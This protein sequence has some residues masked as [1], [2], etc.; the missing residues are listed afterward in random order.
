[1]DNFVRKNNTINFTSYPQK[2][3]ISH[4]TISYLLFDYLASIGT[5]TVFLVPGGGNMFLVDAAGR[6]P[7]IKCICTHNEQAAVIAAESYSRI[8]KEVGVALVTTGPGATNS[9]TG[10]AGAWLDSVPILIISGQVKRADINNENL[11]RQ[12]GPQEIDIVSM[13]KGI[14]KYSKTILDPNIFLNELQKAV[15]ISK[16]G[17]PGPCLIDIPLDIQSSELEIPNEYNESNYKEIPTQKFR[18]DNKL[19]KMMYELKKSKKPLLLM[20]MGVKCSDSVKLAKKLIEITNIP[21]AFTWPVSDILPYNHDL[22]VG[23]P[24]VVAKRNA[25]IT[26][27]NSDFL[28]SIGARLDRIV[29]AF[30]PENFA[31]NAKLFCVD[32]DRAELQKHPKR[33]RTI[34]SDAGFFIENLLEKINKVKYVNTNLRWNKKCLDLK[35][36]YGKNIFSKKTKFSVYQVVENLSKIIPKHSIIITGS[37]GLSIEVFHT[38][39]INKLGQK[40]IIN[41]EGLGSMGYGFPSLLGAAFTQNQELF[42]FESDGSAMMN[43]QELQTLKT[44]KIKAKIFIIN[45]S[46]YVSIKN[47]QKNYFGGR[48]LGVDKNSGIETS[49]IADLAKALKIKSYKIKNNHDFNQKVRKTLRNDEFI[50]Y[51]VFVDD[52]EKL[53]PKCSAFNL[54]QGKMI[55]APLEDMSPL[56]DINDLQKVTTNIDDLSLQIRNNEFNN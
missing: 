4:D 31:K 48:F 41:S 23:R 17:R 11:V 16:S 19:E 36:K 34:L 40:I 51:E 46:G 26:I 42:L 49:S 38:H 21:T 24:G 45:N 29:T 56:L 9:I 14:T 35:K 43:L 28:L 8:N 53:L 37:S 47:T 10:I 33:F 55:S 30:N 54:G 6:H 1:M 52:D 39:F 15:S 3:K 27:Q 18:I 2:K 22:Y 12:K 7:E 44:N 13:V 50:I 20:G 5:K 32:V 25:N